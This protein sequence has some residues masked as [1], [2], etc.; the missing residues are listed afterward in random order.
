[1]MFSLAYAG[2]HYVSDGI[3]GALCAFLI[4]R[5][6]ARVERWYRAR[7]RAATTG[8]EPAPPQDGPPAGSAPAHTVEHSGART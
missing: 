8:V 3:A 4:H 2:E 5:A 6:A 1:M 7:R